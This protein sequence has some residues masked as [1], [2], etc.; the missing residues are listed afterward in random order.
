[1][2]RRLSQAGI[3]SDYVER[4]DRLWTLSTAPES[5]A[6]NPLLLIGAL[7]LDRTRNDDKYR[8]FARR[9]VESLL[10]SQKPTGAMSGDTGDHG[11]VAAAAV[12]LFALQYNDDPLRENIVDAMRR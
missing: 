7:E 11:D 4:A 3:D 1:V 8:Q 5:A 9:S 6:S 12:T 2:A 10:R